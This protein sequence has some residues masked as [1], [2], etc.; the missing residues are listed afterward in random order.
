MAGKKKKV[1]KKKV[2]KKSA[3]E[4]KAEPAPPPAIVDD[5][6][7]TIRGTSARGTTQM[8]RSEYDKQQKK[9]G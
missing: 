9:S 8:T 5:D 2:A 7:V 4:P 6:I 3:I 1:A